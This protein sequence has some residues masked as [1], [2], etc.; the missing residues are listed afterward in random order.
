MPDVSSKKFAAVFARALT[1]SGRLS[2]ADLTALKRAQS[3]ISNAKERAAA[4]S[5]MSLVGHD[6][7]LDSFEL[8]PVRKALGV[9]IG[10]T[11]GPLPPDLEAVLKNAVPAANVKVKHYGLTF[12]L[13][14]KRDAF[15]ARAEVTLDARATKDTVLEVNPDR[16][17]I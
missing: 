2:K 17:T 15:P 8:D 10:V 6:S 11:K 5:I 4:Q 9:L 14:G 12:D 13:S 3:G 1:D 16:L 7:E